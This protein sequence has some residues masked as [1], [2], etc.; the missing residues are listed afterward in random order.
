MCTSRLFKRKPPVDPR[1]QLSPLGGCER[2]QGIIALLGI[3]LAN[4]RPKRPAQRQPAPGDGLD[5]ERG[6]RAGG[7]TVQADA[8]DT[9][10]GGGEG[11]RRDRAAYRVEHQG[12]AA[13]VR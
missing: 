9:V 8:A 7:V 10:R 11:G 13:P 1:P 6:P 2:L 4:N 12:R 3:G 5:V